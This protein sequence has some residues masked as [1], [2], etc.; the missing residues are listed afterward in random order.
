MSVKKKINQGLKELSRLPYRLLDSLY[1]PLDRKF[2][3]KTRNIR[4]IPK[5]HYRRGGKYSYAEWAHVIGIFQTLMCLY[6]DKKYDNRIL[7][8][9]CG[10]GLMGIASEPFLS[11][12]GKYLGIDVIGENIDYCR[13]HYASSLFDFIHFDASNPLYAPGQ[14]TE[15]TPWPVEDKS[16]DMVTALSVWTHL[17]EDDA[18]YYFKEVGRVLKEGGKAIITFFCLDEEYENNLHM[19]SGNE[20]RYHT[21]RQDKWIFDQ[22]VRGSVNWLHPPWVEVPE[23]AVGITS[24][25]FEKLLDSSGMKLVDSHLGNWKEMPGVFFQDVFV[26]EKIAGQF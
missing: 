15:K 14:Q 9:G 18:V 16:F 24:A 22:P 20:G 4:K 3:F 23:H 6:L 13:R 19:R 10:T 1:V 11:P 2:I 26:F 7:D 8:V 5:E 17:D 25:G 21:S 12:A